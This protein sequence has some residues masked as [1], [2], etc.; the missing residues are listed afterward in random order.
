MEY[1]LKLLSEMEKKF[2]KIPVK[3]EVQ[4]LT[5]HKNKK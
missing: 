5:T 2:T 4:W 3:E 1:I